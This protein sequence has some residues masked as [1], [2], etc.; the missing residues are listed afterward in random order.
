MLQKACRNKAG[1]RRKNVTIALRILA[2][3]KEALGHDE[4]QI[5]FR[6]CHG[7]VEQP[8]LLL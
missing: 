2:M 7:D 1:S 3:S 6:A 5:V 8:P 4:A